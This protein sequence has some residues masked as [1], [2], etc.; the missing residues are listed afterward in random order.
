MSTLLRCCLLVASLLGVLPCMATDD[1]R[2]DAPWRAER[3]RLLETI[4]LDFRATA[5][6]TGVRAMSP[7][8]AAALERVPRHRFVPAGSRAAAYANRPLLIG[9][10][11]T[12]SQP[13][14]VALM[15]ELAAVEAGDRVLEIGTGSGYQAAVLAELGADV[16]TIEIVAALG[17]RAAALLAELGYDNV[18]VRIGDGTAG[19]PD[20]APFDAIVVTAGGE[21]PAALVAQLAPGG[22][23]VIPLDSARGELDL[24]VI[25]K[26]ADGAITRETVLPVRFVPLV[27][28]DG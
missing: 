4:R 18:T 21:L 26:A 3:T 5:G 7:A 23:R 19:W 17:E 28:G 12:I 10:G 1:T 27:G 20:A 16:F 15:T 14:I 11:Q 13:F 24:T 22:R 2:A 8:V 6:L 9:H 25:H